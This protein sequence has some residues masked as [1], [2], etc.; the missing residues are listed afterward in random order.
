MALLQEALENTFAALS[1]DVSAL[2]ATYR[3]KLPGILEVFSRPR[4]GPFCQ[5]YGFRHIAALDRDLGWDATRPA[6]V[7]RLW[8]LIYEEEPWCIAMSPPCGKL[9]KLQNLTPDERRRDPEGHRREVKEALAFV[10]LCVEIA[11][12]QLSR[13]RRGPSWRQVVPT[14][15]SQ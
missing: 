10:D 4:L 13:G 14:P 1:V 2:A 15:E 8:E 5:R 7:R 11:R 12:Y 9:S 3:E 6:D